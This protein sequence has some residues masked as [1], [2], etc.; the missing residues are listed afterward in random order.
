MKLTSHFDDLLRNTVNLNQTRIDNLDISSE[1]LKNFLRQR[2]WKAEILGFSEQ[3]SWAHDTIIKPVDQG[4]FDAD[5]LMLVNPVEGW[6]A[7]DY[8]K[9][10]KS[11][12]AQSETYKGLVKAW[13]YCVTITYAKDHKVDIAPLVVDRVW[14]GDLEVCNKKTNKFVPSEPLQYTDWLISRNALSGANSFRKVTRLFKYLRDIK[15]TFTC[16]SVLLTTLLAMQIDESDKD[17]DA[18]SDVPTSLSTLAGRLDDFLQQNENRPAVENPFMPGEDFAQA[19][20]EVQYKNFRGMIHK[21]RG[22]IDNALAEQDRSASILGWRQIFGDEFASGMSVTKSALIVETASPARA[23]LMGT[24]AHL[25]ALVDVVRKFGTSI[26]PADFNRPPHMKQPRWP[27]STQASFPVVVSASHHSS[28]DSYYG[29]PLQSGD[30]LPPQGGL[31]FDVT[32][33]TGQALPDG[34]YVEWRVTNT[35]ARAMALGQGRG[36]FE[37]PQRGARRWETL[38]YRGVHI[39]EAFVVDRTTGTLVAQSR[40]FHV[41]IE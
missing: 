7:A 28:R 21:Y 5:L 31:W 34:H 3:G 37:V 13:D 17:G 12:F 22:W 15:G 9:E 26:L 20:T 19:W 14:T 40:P 23:L 36:G 41:V 33:P 39:A 10:L 38:T 4:E 25:D 24:A 35:G 2:E 18:F 27:R 32:L 29:E 8:I 6:S 11:L 1:A 16:S 30:A